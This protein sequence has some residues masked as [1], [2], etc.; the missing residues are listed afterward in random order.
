MEWTTQMD[1]TME[2]PIYVIDPLPAPAPAG[3]GRFSPV[4]DYWRGTKEYRRLYRKFF[5]LL[6]KVNCYYDFK[7]SFGEKW[8]ANPSPEKLAG[9][10][11]DCTR[12][13]KDYLNIFLDSDQSMILLNGDALSLAVYSPGKKLRRLLEQLAQSEGLFFWRVEL[14]ETAGQ[15]PP[16]P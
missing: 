10:V 1:R 14:A 12:G 8:A 7:V 3:R 6:L 9:W 15:A 11:K 4:E 13:Q 2:G 5:R 16:L